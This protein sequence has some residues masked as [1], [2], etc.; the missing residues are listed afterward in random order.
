MDDSAGIMLADIIVQNYM[1]AWWSPRGELPCMAR[2][3][4]WGPGGRPN[5]QFF[6]P[7]KSKH[8]RI[9]VENQN[10][11][12]KKTKSIE[13]MMSLQQGETFSGFKIQRT[14]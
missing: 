2:A 3:V 11:R 4:A 14:V 7:K 8:A 1:C 6:A 13:R 5:S 12:V 10:L 9:K